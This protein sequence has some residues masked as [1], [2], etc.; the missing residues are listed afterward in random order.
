MS[1][2]VARQQR[3]PQGLRLRDPRSDLAPRLQTQL[4]K[5]LLNMPFGGPPRDGQ[6]LGDLAIAPAVSHQD[7]HLQLS[8]SELPE[9]CAHQ[10][11]PAPLKHSRPVVLP[12]TPTWIRPSVDPWAAGAIGSR[13]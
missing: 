8:P 2:P 13:S 6:L 12:V 4:G 3:D 7:R 11:S 10:P 9:L 1:R 5:D